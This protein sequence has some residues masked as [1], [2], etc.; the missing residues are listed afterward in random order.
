MG[1]L[2]HVA[3]DSTRVRANASRRR[4]ETVAELRQRLAVTRR[5]IRRWQQQCAAR[6]DHD[7]DPGTKVKP[8]FR[9]MLD[10]QLAETQE[11]LQKLEKMG[12]AQLSCTDP[13]SRFLHQSQGKGFVLGYTVDLAVSDDHLIVAQRTTAGGRRQRIAAAPARQGHGNLRRVAGTG[14]RR[15]ATFSR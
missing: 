5:M 8:N 15:L 6:S 10:Q 1:R 3:I 7:E 14:E 12:A 9:Q 2:G 4:T 11:K 13:D